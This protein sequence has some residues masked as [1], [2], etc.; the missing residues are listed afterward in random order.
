MFTIPDAKKESERFVS[1]I[2]K[3]PKCGKRA[4]DSWMKPRGDK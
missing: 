4:P 3:C 2:V 1:V